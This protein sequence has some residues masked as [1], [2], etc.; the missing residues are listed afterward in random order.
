MRAAGPDLAGWAAPSRPQPGA[1]GQ[2]TRRPAGIWAP[3]RTRHGHPAGCSTGPA[4]DHLVQR[5]TGEVAAGYPAR[6]GRRRPGRPHRP[7]RHGAAVLRASRGCPGAAP[8]Q[9]ARPRWR[10]RGRALNSTEQ[11]ATVLM[12]ASAVAATS[13]RY[14][15]RA[16][17]GPAGPPPTATR[18]AGPGD[19]P[20][21]TQPGRGYRVPGRAGDRLA[22]RAAEWRHRAGLR[23]FFV[24]M[25]RGRV[26]PVAPVAGRGGSTV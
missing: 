21:R 15:G 19:S 16:G 25:S 9:G 4:R 24:S 3:P 2:L 5:M 1:A 20:P 14:P 17:P 10:P 7:G 11:Q 23:S 18:A 12:A 26:S 8:A 22:E 13:R 6:P